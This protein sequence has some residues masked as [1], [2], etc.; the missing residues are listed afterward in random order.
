M[1]DSEHALHEE[2]HPKVPRSRKIL[3]A[4][5]T[6]IITLA[7]GFMLLIIFWLLYPYKT[8]EIEVP[9]EVLN[10]NHQIAQGEQI[11]LKVH[12]TK[13][14]NVTPTRSEFITCDDGSLTFIN[15]GKSTNLSPGSYTVINDYNTLPFKL[16]PGSICKYHFHYGYKVNPIREIVNEWVSD[17]FLVLKGDD[18]NAT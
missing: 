17:T 18:P 8:A 12:V 15:P 6:L 5:S 4:L 1:G 14:S 10:T 13:Y 9:V 3:Y 11:V 2:P 16:A 7:I